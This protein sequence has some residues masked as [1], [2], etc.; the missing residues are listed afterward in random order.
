MTEKKKEIINELERL[1]NF[2]NHCESAREYGLGL[3][4]ETYKKYTDSLERQKELGE[5]LK[6][7]DLNKNGII[8]SAM[9][10]RKESSIEIDKCKVESIV[11]L[12]YSEFQDFKNYLFDNRPFIEDNIDYMYRDNEGINH[13]LLVLG[14]G[15]EDGILVESEGYSYAR[16]SAL[17][18][19]AR[20]YIQKNIQTMAEDL[21]KQGTA[22]TAN[23]SWVIGFDEISQHFD[24]TITP[25][26]GIGQ[27]LIKEL[28][29]R[30]EVAEIIATED[31]IEMTY[32]L[33]HAPV[34]DDAKERL[35]NMIG[36]MGCN[37]EDTSSD[38][39][40]EDE[41]EEKSLSENDDDETE[42]FS[43]PTMSM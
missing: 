25:T 8:T 1:Q 30:D 34:T 9:L 20:S 28:E 24:T 39:E 17:L 32:Y 11:E 13:C 3:D 4:E 19:N 31:Y 36:M 5:Q 15:E 12:S 21:I 6:V 33:D 37:I 43:S 40:D 16:Y 42:D 10:M 14:E 26:N 41:D 7:L 35:S 27:M 22:Q 2:I 29:T 23:G 18:P 38:D